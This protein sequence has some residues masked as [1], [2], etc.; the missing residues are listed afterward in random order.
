VSAS[1]IRSSVQDTR[2]HQFDG[3]DDVINNGQ[4]TEGRAYLDVSGVQIGAAAGLYWEPTPN[5]HLGASYTSQPNFGTMRMSGTFQFDSP[6]ETIKPQNVDFL[7]AYPDVIRLGGTWRVAP[8]AELRL[9]ASYQRWSVFNQQCVV[10][11]GQSCSLTSNGGIPSSV[12]DPKSEVILNVPRNFQDTVKVRFGGAYWVSASAQ[13][14]ASGSFETSAVPN[15]YEDALVFDSQRLSGTLG[16]KYGFT[17]HIYGMAAY[18]YTYFLPVTVTNSA[19]NTESA[20]SKSPSENGSY[21]SSL[22]V[23]D[24]ALSYVF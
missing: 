9:D 8:D 16:L 4:V 6:G 7:Q 22:Y 13:A 12:T 21:T 1:V 19:Y 3:S 5:L 20:P 17:K 23:L 14:F 18:T 10:P 24:A 15:A 2:A 11:S